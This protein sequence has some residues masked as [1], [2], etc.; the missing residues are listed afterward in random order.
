[1]SIN[2]SDISKYITNSNNEEMKSHVFYLLKLRERAKEDINSFFDKAKE[3]TEI[4]NIPPTIHRL[5]I[6]IQLLETMITYIVTK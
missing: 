2:N 3:D 1:M 4:Y 5:R 6:E